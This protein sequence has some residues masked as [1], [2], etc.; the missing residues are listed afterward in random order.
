MGISQMTN[1]VIGDKKRWR[2]FKRR[3]A[4]LPPSYQTAVEGMMRYFTH[5]GGMDDAE[6]IL[7]MLDDLATLFEQAAADGTPVRVVVG[8]DPVEF[9]EAFLSNY[10]A[11]KWIKRERNRLTQAIAEA[12]AMEASA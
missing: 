4:A 5:L 6:S 9:A 3:V 10:P 11:G 8:E 2:E 1:K 7:T 12:E